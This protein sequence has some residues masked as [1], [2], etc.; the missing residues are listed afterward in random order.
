MPELLTLAVGGAALAVPAVFGV[1][2][3][4]AARARALARASIF[5]DC[6]DLFDRPRLTRA[7]D[8]F[9]RLDGTRG[10]QAFDLR[11]LPD[12]LSYR[13]LP[14]LWLMVTLL[15]PQPVRGRC[16][17]L[18][19]PTGGEP[20]SPFGQ[21]PVQ[22][23]PPPGCPDDA[24]LR[25]DDPE[26][27]PDPAVLA[28]HLP[29]LSEPAAKELLIAPQ[30]LRLVWLADEAERTRYLIYRDAELGRTPVPGATAR[31][32]ADALAAL[33]GDLARAAGAAASPERR[34]A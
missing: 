11:V 18:L 21:L 10:G 7:P 22:C 6:R 5:D 9:A 25:C 12:M 8:G 31:R 28:P 33:H 1:A 16:D 34:I 23:P 4:R 19:R 29:I 2:A 17:I 13:K 15:A 24:A 3:R 30:G 14:T 20:F 27:L 26:D 32:L